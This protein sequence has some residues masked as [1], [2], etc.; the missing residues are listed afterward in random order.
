MRLTIERLGHRG[1]GIGDG[2][3][4]PRAL[5]GEEVEGTVTGDRMDAPRIVT[6]SP[7][8]VTPPCAHYRNCG[9]CALQH[10]TDGFVGEWKQEVVRT[11]LAAQGLAAPVRALHT[12]PPG[13]RRRAT[14]A[15]RRLKRGTMVG[16]HA[17]ASDVLTEI[18]ECRVLHPDILATLPA[19]NEI[20]RLGATRK[21]EIALTVTRSDAGPDVA[22]RGGKP[23]DAALRAELGALTGREGLARLAWDGEVLACD[24]PP[25][26]TFGAARVTPP[27]GAFLQATQE[28]EA[29]LAAAILEAVG[30][31]RR[32]VE[33]FAG[34]GTFALPMAASAEVHAVEGDT[35][36]LEALAAGW[37]QA[38]GL[39]LVTTETRD[40]FRDPLVANEVSR[41]EA[42]V[43]DPP[44]AGAA[45]QTAEIARARVPVIAMASCN[46][47]TFA[48]DAR[49]LR[50]AG[51]FLDWI[52][53]VDQFRW[54]PHV[55]LVARFALE[56]ATG[57]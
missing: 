54:S 34:C 38:L 12:S 29:A 36:M 26:Q 3:F 32:I 47:V 44:R 49:T 46:P 35:A 27:P 19:L 2:I 37:R 23:L 1:D 20:T 15:G 14:L 8:R 41:Y 53:V 5:P 40:L 51:Y 13:T 4:V 9:G 42:A 24:T 50:D 25:A 45:A 43:L 30:P 55:E 22:V 33:L 31:A 57:E 7:D 39:K 17:R 52:R 48:R 6:P 16:F 21:G 11:A 10:A 28:G 18:P 56:H